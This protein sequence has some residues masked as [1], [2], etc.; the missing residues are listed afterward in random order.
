MP[1]MTAD[2]RPLVEGLEVWEASTFAWI[3]HGYARKTEA[4]TWYLV[5]RD[6]QVRGGSCQ[7]QNLYTTELSAL[8]RW[9]EHLLKKADEVGERIIREEVA[10]GQAAHIQRAVDDEL[11]FQTLEKMEKP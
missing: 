5:G 2:D 1:D 3:T 4:G 6:G 8:R 10:I 11:L 7:P 9:Q